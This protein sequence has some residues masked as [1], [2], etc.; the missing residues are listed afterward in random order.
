MRQMGC[1]GLAVVLIVALF[2]YDQWRIEQLKADVSAIAAKVHVQTEK[3]DNNKKIDKSNNNK[4]LVTALANA[5]MHTKRAKELL[6]KN[7][8]AEANAELDKALKSL[9][10]ANNVSRDIAGDAAEYLGKARN[11]AEELFRSAWHDISAE[12][13]PVKQDVKE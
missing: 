12:T 4:D 2:V 13:K 6:E 7:R 8:K 3:K 10:S 1:L 11:R 9:D 5:E